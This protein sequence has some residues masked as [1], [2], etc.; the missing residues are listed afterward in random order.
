[1]KEGEAIEKK[2]PVDF[3]LALAKYVESLAGFAALGVERPNLAKK[4]AE[5]NK[6]IDD[7]ATC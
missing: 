3:E 6:W 2:K 4:V 5:I 1:M 7:E